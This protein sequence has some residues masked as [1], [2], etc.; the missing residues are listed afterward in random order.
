MFVDESKASGYV[1]AAVAVAP[2]AV[3][4]TE[5]ALRALRAGGRSAIHF[6]EEGNRRQQLLKQFVQLDVRAVVYLMKGAKD[7]VARPAI[8]RGLVDDLVTAGAAELIIE[9]DASVE[10]VDRRVIRDRLVQVNALGAVLY[11]HRGRKEQPMLWIADAVAWC[12]QAGAGWPNRIADI[13]QATVEVP[14]P[15]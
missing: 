4:P 13:V 6:N 15:R 3:A 8:L 5:R 14:A 7:R 1:V 11:G 2:D 12:H 9:R 10:V